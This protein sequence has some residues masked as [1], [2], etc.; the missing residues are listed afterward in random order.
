MKKSVLFIMFLYTAILFGQTDVPMDMVILLDRSGSMRNTDPDGVTLPAAAF[1]VEQ[2]MLANSENR[3]AVITFASDVNILGRDSLTTANALTSGFLAVLEM[4][5]AGAGRGAFNFIEN[6]PSNFSDFQQLLTTQLKESGE[7]EMGLALET[8]LSTLES[9]ETGRIKTIVMISDGM[10]EPLINARLG[11]ILGQQTIRQSKAVVFKKYRDYMLAEIAPKLA[12]AG[13]DFYPVAFVSDE[14][15][16]PPFVSFLKQLKKEITGD[17]EIIV[18]DRKNLVSKLIGFIPSNYNHILVQRVENF[19][20]GNEASRNYGLQIPEIARNVR[21]FVF[22]QGAKSGQEI[23]FKVGRNGVAVAGTGISSNQQN[24]FLNSFRDRRGRVV[25]FSCFVFGHPSAGDRYTVSLKSLSTVPLPI[26]HLLVDINSRLYPALTQVPVEPSAKDP[27]DFLCQIFDIETRKTMKITGAQFW[28][29]A[30]S[31]ES[32]RGE[33]RRIVQMDIRQDSTLFQVVFPNAGLYRMSGRVNFQPVDCESALNLNFSQSVNVV[34]DIGLFENVYIA[35]KEKDRD[36][37]FKITLPPLGEETSVK[38]Q[39]LIVRSM[40]NRSINN[41]ILDIPPA[42][43]AE[44]GFSLY[45]GGKG[46]ISAN[47][48]KIIGLTT[49]K[50]V[51]FTLSAEIPDGITADIPDGMY[52]TVLR[53][54]DGQIELDLVPVQLYI[55]IPR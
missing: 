32:I 29:R 43:N 6:I 10:P 17:D 54:L 35:S 7:T 3:V 16:S 9:A 14:S 30:L 1:I 21:F 5:Q 15:Q 40:L 12:R 47:P 38:Y 50:P 42:Q 45:S 53:L 28:F 34:S 31:P 4:L 20:K 23:D 39:N 26:S 52:S 19:T 55:N 33:T 48:G 11:K 2:L 27:V 37:D 8:A 46:W 49:G 22:C 18:T 41:L 13:I 25:Y 24:I 36:E 51:P 44:S